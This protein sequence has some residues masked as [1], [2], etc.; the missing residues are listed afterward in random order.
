MADSASVCCHCLRGHHR[1]QGV[2]LNEVTSMPVDESRSEPAVRA[3]AGIEDVA[4]AAGVSVATVSRAIRGLPNVAVAT[5]ERVLA[6]AAE[7]RYQADPAAARLA[8]G[9]TRTVAVGV[10]DPATWFFAKVVGGIERKLLAAGYDLLLSGIPDAAHRSRFLYMNAPGGRRC[11]ASILVNVALVPEEAGEAVADGHRLVTVGFR[12]EGFSSVTIDNVTAAS[13][14][15]EHLISLGH[16]RIGLMGMVM[17]NAMN[18]VVP[19]MRRQGYLR[20]HEAAGLQ[21]DPGIESVANSTS[22]ASRVIGRTMLDSPDRPS[23]VFA[24]SDEQAFGVMLA[25]QDL[26]LNVPEDL[27]VVGVDDHD[28]SELIGLTTVRQGVDEL[29]EAIEGGTVRHVE[30]PTELIL[31][32]STAPRRS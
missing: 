23:A 17:D 26:G 21:V 18:F 10:P 12:Y 2:R 7:L 15:V 13:R 16:R 30:V 4:L 27:S 31:R 20:A 1:S 14:A 9:S 5:R 25:A 22:D 11:D 3:R 8:A 6:V 29:L 32:S 24:M 19:P 28:Q